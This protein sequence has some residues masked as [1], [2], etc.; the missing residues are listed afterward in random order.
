MGGS[1]RDDWIGGWQVG[2]GRGKWQSKWSVILWY[3]P[4]N[5]RRYALLQVDK[6]QAGPIGATAHQLG[7]KVG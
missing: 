3:A 2:M 4:A 1:R 5:S 7:G 6:R